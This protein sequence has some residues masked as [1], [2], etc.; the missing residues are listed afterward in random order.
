LDAVIVRVTLKWRGE[1]LSRSAYEV[2]EGF[3]EVGYAVPE[4][5]AVRCLK[6]ECSLADAELL[7]RLRG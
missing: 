4:D 1:V 2:D 5:V 3:I 6:E 7:V